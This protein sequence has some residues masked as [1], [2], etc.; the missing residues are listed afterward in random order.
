MTMPL[1]TYV[2][3]SEFFFTVHSYWTKGSVVNYVILEIKTQ[4]KK[5]FMCDWTKLWNSLQVSI[6]ST[7]D[8]D[9]GVSQHMTCFVFSPYL[10]RAICI[11]ISQ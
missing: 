1:L 6:Q 4:G 8:K 7:E 9:K 5:T 3:L 10:M 11:C 2:S